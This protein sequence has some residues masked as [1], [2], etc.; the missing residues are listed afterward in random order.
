MSMTES[1]GWQLRHHGTV[2]L[3]D[4]L[5]VEK[6]VVRASSNEDRRQGLIQLMQHEQLKRF[7]SELS[8]LHERL[9]CAGE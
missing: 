7:G 2:G 1:P 4:R 8:P 9:N 6:L 5:V 3:I